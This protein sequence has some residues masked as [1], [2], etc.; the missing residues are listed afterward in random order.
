MMRR[1]FLLPGR[2]LDRKL[3]VKSCDPHSSPEPAAITQ[4]L[5]IVKAEGPGLLRAPQLFTLRIPQ[6]LLLLSTLTSPLP[7]SPPPNDNLAA[8][9]VLT[10]NFW[11]TAGSLHE[12]TSEPNEPILT[13]M[14]N[15]PTAWWSWTPTVTGS[16]RFRTWGSERAN[17]LA[18]YRGSSMDD[19]RLVGFDAGDDFFDRANS[20]DVSFSATAGETY[21][22]QVLGAHFTNPFSISAPFLPSRLQ[23]SMEPYETGTFIPPNDNFANAATLTG[24]GQVLVCNTNATS[25]AGEPLDIPGARSNTAWIAWTAPSSGVWAVNSQETDFDNFVAVYTGSAVNALTRLGYSDF[26]GGQGPDVGGGMVVFRATG[27]TTY[28]IQLTG[29]AIAGADYG[30][31]RLSFLPGA[32]PANDDFTNALTLT[33]TAPAADGW[34]TFATREIGEPGSQGDEAGSLWWNWTATSSGTLALISYAGDVEAWTGASVVA[35]AALP[36]DQH[37]GNRH[38]LGGVTYFYTVTGGTVVRL[39]LTPGFGRGAFALRMLTTPAN[40]DFANRATLTGNTVILSPDLTGASWENTEPNTDGSGPPSVWYRWTA[41]STRRVVFGPRNLSGPAQVYFYTGSTL[42]GLTRVPNFLDGAGNSA[43]NSIAAVSGTEY[44]IQAR[45]ASFPPGLAPFTIRPAAPPVN[46]N[47]ASA[48]VMSGSA[49]TA[50]GTNVDA[51]AEANEFG[52]LQQDTTATSSVWWRWTAPAA[53]LFRVS[54]AGSAL[55]SVLT[56]QTGATLAAQVIVAVDQSAA[57]LS[58]GA[59]IFNAVSGTTY[60]LRVDGQSRSE[61]AIQLTLQ[62]APAPPNDSFGSRLVL[63]GVGTTATGNVLGATLEGGEANPSAPNGGRSVWYDWT[64]PASGTAFFRVT[65]E[66]FSPAFGLYNGSAVGSLTQL[67]SGGS[68]AASGTA[69][70]FFISY[71]VSSGTNYKIRVDGLPATNGSFQI[72]ISIPAPPLNDTFASRTRLAGAVVRSVTNNVARPR[73]PANPRTPAA[74]RLSLSGTNGP[75]RR[76]AA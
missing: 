11:L 13:Y 66:R 50:T 48:T 45:P 10:G 76:P 25:E 9:T 14:P 61:G 64:A 24:A 46:D 62:P 69:Q 52:P 54:T 19:L 59:V 43:D 75:R 1:F 29:N 72:N 33:G 38:T 17:M 31:C 3:S 41:P 65:A 51:T 30:V 44:A 68:G 71:P 37:S 35:L 47:F 56:V 60:Y 12:A 70:S 4:R 6:R 20:A 16:V 7:A 40:D 22:I 28:R 26:I 8:A 42:T 36:F 53:G 73:R 2:I 15:G 23:L 63:S 67:V 34:G 58:T 32:P 21:R 5:R 49:W 39:R 55:D 74:R 27:G 18:V 57:W